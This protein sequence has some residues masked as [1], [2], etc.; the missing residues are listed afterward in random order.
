MKRL[1]VGIPFP[2]DLRVKIEPVLAELKLPGVSPVAVENLHLTIKFLGEVEEKKLLEIE[3]KLS[4]LAS[5]TPSFPVEFRGI[6]AFPDLKQPQVV[7]I[8]AESKE[9]VELMRTAD[10]ELDYIHQNEHSSEIPH[11]TLARIKRLDP[12]SDFDNFLRGYQNR[13][14]G[15][16]KVGKICLFEAKLTPKGPI[17]G[18]LSEN[19]LKTT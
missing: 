9:L 2:P 8:G 15:T 18:V 14:W 19:K 3:E 12:L 13:R 7:W 4:K 16:L 11:L 1:F 10:K 6:G 5:L 17:Y